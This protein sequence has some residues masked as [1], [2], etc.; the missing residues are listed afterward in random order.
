MAQGVEVLATIPDWVVPTHEQVVAMLRS[1]SRR[2]SGDHAFGHQQAAS[3]ATD[4]ISATP[5]SR[6]SSDQPVSWNEARAECW[7]AVCAAAE[8]PPPTAHEFA[9]LGA[10]A[11][12]S[13]ATDP[14][15]AHGVWQVLAWLLGE[16]STPPDPGVVLDLR[17][18]HR[19]YLELE[20]LSRQRVEARQRCEQVRQRIAAR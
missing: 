5:I 14:D 15:Y 10:P 13:A 12:P 17:L 20:R 9:L 8:Q 3:W 1:D 11:R 19:E 4:I 16:R 7:M 2:T 6:R 18:A